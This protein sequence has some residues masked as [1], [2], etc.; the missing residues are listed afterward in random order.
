MTPAPQHQHSIPG[1]AGSLRTSRRRLLA[2]LG[3][4]GA[5]TLAAPLGGNARAA[6]T[7]RAAD[8]TSAVAP[9]PLAA[10]RATPA[11]VVV[12]V[13]D[14]GARGDG[15]VDDT[16]AVQAAIDQGGVTWFPPGDYSCRTLTM[17]KATRLAGVNSGTY[18]Y[19]NGRYAADYPL[20]TVSRIV[21]RAN[22]NA[23]LIVGPVG[24]KHV[25]LEDLELD[26]NN[27]AQSANNAHV[28]SLVDSPTAEDTQ[29]LIS[30]CYIHGRVDPGAARWGSGG[31]NV[32]I[33]GNRMACHL[34]NCVSNYA[35]Y[36][37]LEINGADT[38]ADACIIGD[39][40]AEGI[41]IGAWV[42]TV[43]ACALYNNTNAVYVADTGNASPKR[44][45]ISGNGIDRN[46]QNGILIDKG[47]TTGAAGVSIMN[48]AF[49]TNSTDRDNTC[50]HV[51]IKATTGNV[52]LGGNVFSEV[53]AGYS[54]RTASA[55]LLG[56]GASALD[57][58]NIYEG[59]S[60]SGFT[61]APASLYT[62]T[63]SS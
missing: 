23:P 63:K 58:G 11:P 51:N 44:I 31:S 12:N 20:G 50:G 15:V 9:S 36:H 34:V 14:L 53:E 33:G 29:W 24:A 57:M 38:V 8:P 5:A 22:T 62:T 42:T 32:Y 61:N 55:V 30:R 60:V 41:V 17:R 47:A 19:A 16:A 1:I 52:V 48:N 39:N 26:G 43:S 6:G 4:T 18:T 56:P 7:R 46:R 13:K 59:G 37:G 40:G 54:N 10:P 35:H 3:A 2:V 27:P 25:I 28:V 21:R 49:T 45:L